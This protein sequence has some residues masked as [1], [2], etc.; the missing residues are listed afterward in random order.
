[1]IPVGWGWGDDYGGWLEVVVALLVV[2]AVL[3]VYV[4][5]AV[6]VV[7]VVVMWHRVVAQVVR[8]VVNV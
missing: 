6:V 2:R 3:N 5:I 8:D 7:V 1:M 4:G